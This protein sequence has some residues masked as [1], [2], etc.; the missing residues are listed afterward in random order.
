MLNQFGVKPPINKC[1]VIPPS[2]VLETNLLQISHMGKN[3]PFWIPHNSHSHSADLC[4]NSKP[5]F[6]HIALL[7]YEYMLKFYTEHMALII[8][9]PLLPPVWGSV[10]I[11]GENISHSLERRDAE[12]KKITGRK[13]TGPTTSDVG[14]NDAGKVLNN[15][16]LI[17][18]LIRFHLQM[19]NVAKKKI[20]S[21]V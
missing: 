10:L 11:K 20:S 8:F 2:V 9:F 6:G 12:Q 4:L 15:T 21:Q 16:L 3:A 14:C 1:P 5:L 18:Q 19:T 13:M 17:K 7:Y